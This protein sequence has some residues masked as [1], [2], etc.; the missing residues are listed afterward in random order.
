MKDPNKATALMIQ[1][2]KSL[3]ICSSVE[4]FQVAEKLKALLK[5]DFI[6]NDIAWSWL[7]SAIDFGEMFRSSLTAV[8]SDDEFFVGV[9]NLYRMYVNCD[10]R[11]DSLHVHLYAA[12]FCMFLK[13]NSYSKSQF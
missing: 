7:D 9:D 11:L 5:R 12:H 3:K 1:I 6:T 4:I 8:G 10:D 2:V 13:S